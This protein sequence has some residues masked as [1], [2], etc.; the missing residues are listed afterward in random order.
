MLVCHFMNCAI[1][2]LTCGSRMDSEPISESTK[3]LD[4]IAQS[5]DMNRYPL[6]IFEAPKPADYQTF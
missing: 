1:L 3:A 6:E 5:P 4:A 2:M